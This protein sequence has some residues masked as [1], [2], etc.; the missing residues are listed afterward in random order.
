MEAA[1]LPLAPRS[2]LLSG[3]RH[4]KATRSAVRRASRLMADAERFERNA[5]RLEAQ[6]GSDAWQVAHLRRS[7]GELRRL[8]AKEASAVQPAALA[9]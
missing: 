8:A 1:S 6:L 2:G 9:A 7:S 4:R 5:L 3:L